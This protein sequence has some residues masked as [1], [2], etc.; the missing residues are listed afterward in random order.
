M[1][2]P[3]PWRMSH[4]TARMARMMSRM[5]RGFCRATRAPAPPTAARQG[6]QAIYLFVNKKHMD[7]VID[8][9]ETVVGDCVEKILNEEDATPALDDVD[10]KGDKVG[11]VV[12]DALHKIHD[13]MNKINP[14]SKDDEE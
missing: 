3:R 11:E 1:E 12:G 2:Q 4:Q 5:L 14:L 7:R 13:T 8:K 9:I 10:T 6:K